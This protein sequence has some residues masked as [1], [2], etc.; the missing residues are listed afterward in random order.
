MVE[1]KSGAHAENRTMRV[2]K[3]FSR[4]ASFV[5]KHDEK[6]PFGIDATMAQPRGL[7]AFKARRSTW[8]T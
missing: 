6:I 3:R 4:S 5:A 8:S 7:K 1:V 2:E